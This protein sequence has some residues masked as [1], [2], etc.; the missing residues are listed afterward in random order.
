MVLH[1]SLP[2]PGD[3][4]WLLWPSVK[5]K[6]YDHSEWNP[7]K[8]DDD[9]LTT[10]TTRRAFLLQMH[11]VDAALKNLLTIFCTLQKSFQYMEKCFKPIDES[12]ILAR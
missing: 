1:P 11:K 7:S 12:G 4:A 5:P 3:I 10:K 8:Y 2:S 9:N 6:I